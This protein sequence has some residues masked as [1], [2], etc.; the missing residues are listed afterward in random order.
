MNLD[1]RDRSPLSP[2]QTSHVINTAELV[3]NVNI[4]FPQVH[5]TL[6]HIILYT[7][8]LARSFRTPAIRA[9]RS[10]STTT[11]RLQ[12]VIP[13]TATCPSPTC[14]C[15]SAPSDLDIDRKTPLLN[16]MAAYSE[17]VIL[18]TGKE[19]WVSN[20]EQE[21]GATGDFVKG[22]KSVIGKGGVGFDVGPFPPLSSLK[23]LF[24][25]KYAT[26]SHSPTSSSPPPHSHKPRLKVQ[27]QPCYSRASS[28][29]A[30][31]HIHLNRSTT[32]RPH[33]SKRAS[34]IPCTTAYPPSR[35]RTSPA[36]NLEPSIC[37]LQSLSRSPRSSYAGT[38]AAINVVGY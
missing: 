1:I 3:P 17:Q 5:P 35:K 26:Y 34:Y 12:S 15:A 24:A 20:I 32:S 19:D 27:Q 16:T 4:I 10:F 9:L 29:F 21:E 13:Y 31:Y 33:T 8:L 23:S 18:C 14:E 38:V 25:D 7:M 30:I 6:I 37:L 36:T 11:T 28:A 22:L 2:T